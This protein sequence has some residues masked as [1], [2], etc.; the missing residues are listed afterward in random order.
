M[1]RISSVAIVIQPVSWMGIRG[2]LFLKKHDWLA[3]YGFRPVDAY[4]LKK[5]NY[6][7]PLMGL[8]RVAEAVEVLIKKNML[9]R[10][11]PQDS[12]NGMK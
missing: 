10:K 5:N 4:I 9:I 2:H 12:F 7:L 6:S 11:F 1:P 8:R 3:A